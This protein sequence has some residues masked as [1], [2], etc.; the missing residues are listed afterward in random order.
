MGKK[1]IGMILLISSLWMLIGCSKSEDIKPIGNTDDHNEEQSIEE[2]NKNV[3][4]NESPGN[5]DIETDT[6]ESSDDTPDLFD[7]DHIDL[8]EVNETVYSSKNVN[9]RMYPSTDSEIITVLKKDDSINRIGFNEEWSKVLFDEKEYYVSSKYLTT[10][11]PVAE[12]ETEETVEEI[13]TKETVEVV[14]PSSSQKL[15][16]IDPGHQ[17][18][19]NSQKEP[20]GP[21]SSRLKAK[22]S[23]GATGVATGLA[24]YELNL[25][26]SMKLKDALINKGYKVIMT[27]ETN[28]VDISNSERAAIA[29][30]A[31]ADVFIRIHANGAENKDVA[32][33]MTISPTKNNSYLSSL[34][35]ECYD[36]SKLVLDNM[37]AATGAKSK[38]V[39]ETDTMSGI[40]WAKV[41]VT[42]VEMGYMS[43]TNEDTL[44]ATPEYQDKIVEGIVN[45][46]EK[47]FNQ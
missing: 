32:G 10:D 37:I 35:G 34:Y 23:S 42:I 27:R 6:N 44:M 9:I 22:V 19:G 20:D 4:T 7:P 39:W 11:E 13:E 16:V 28:D 31:N 24:E 1:I 41:P 12:I 15:I 21:G 18:K 47:Y 25:R 5:E 17:G 38:G 3:E 30:D 40:N 29:N 46:I 14:K 33:I 43:N 26:V 8:E 36:L 45:G 2:T